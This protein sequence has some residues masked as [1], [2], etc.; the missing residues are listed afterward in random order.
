MKQELNK[1]QAIKNIKN[2][3]KNKHGCEDVKKIKKLAMS[4][5]IKLGEKRKLFC[6]KC[7]S[8]NLK[9]LGINNK[10]KRVTCQ[11]CGN[12]TRWRMKD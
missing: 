7:N 2:F 4:Y 11:D 6:N 12:L 1:K 8:M 5:Q 9:V 10:I 3:F